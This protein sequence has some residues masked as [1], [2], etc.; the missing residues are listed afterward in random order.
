MRRTSGLGSF[1]GTVLSGVL[2]GFVLA[3]FVGSFVSGLASGGRPAEPASARTFITSLLK[4]DTQGIAN[5][6]PSEG[7]VARA[8][9]VQSQA[10][11]QQWQPLA[12]SYVGGGEQADV[13]IYMYV[14]KV[15]SSD[16]SQ[17]QSVPFALTI[18][19]GKVVRVQ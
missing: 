16:G 9:R 11:T 18:A 13:G 3:A 15:R 6:R 8:R 14:A 1:V 17:T 4:Q 10:G 19:G 2:V 7:I 12:L 5:S